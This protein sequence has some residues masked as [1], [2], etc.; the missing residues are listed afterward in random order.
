[1]AGERSLASSRRV[2]AILPAMFK[3]RYYGVEQKA[4]AVKDKFQKWGIEYVAFDFDDSLIDT[5]GIFNKGIS[6]ACGL[7]LYADE[8]EDRQKFDDKAR[9]QADLLNRDV[10][11]P[12]LASL[13]PEYGIQPLVMEVSIS[14]TARLSNINKDSVNYHNAID[15]VRAIYEVD[16]PDTF[17]GAIELVDTTNASGAKTLLTTHAEDAWT[18]RKRKE[19]GFYAK[20]AD[21]ICFNVWQPKAEQW[22]GE[23]KEHGISFQNLLVIGDNLKADILPPVSMGARAVLVNNG[24]SASKHT[25]GP[26]YYVSEEVYR[27]RVIEVPRTM[28]IIG[29][30][31]QR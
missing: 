21:V 11:R 12:V 16:V 27:D 31:I 3:E 2:N 1:M 10:F 28:D 29:G 22:E 20:F 8:W 5:R 9:A 30:I 7:L 18:Y 14:I 26:E 24:A 19:C 4:T 6:E 13:R 25:H 23:F 17:P 15:R